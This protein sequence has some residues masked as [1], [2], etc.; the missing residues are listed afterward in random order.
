MKKK[1]IFSANIKRSK[2]TEYTVSRKV[3][4]EFGGAVHHC[5]WKD[6]VLFGMKMSNIR[7]VDQQDRWEERKRRKNYAG[8][9]R[10]VILLFGCDVC[11]FA[12]SPITPDGTRRGRGRLQRKL[13]GKRD[14]E[15]R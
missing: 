3:R 12:V 7:E 9:L 4:T 15:S 5:V 14:E 1:K 2:G 8:D 11:I 13:E 6:C 10:P